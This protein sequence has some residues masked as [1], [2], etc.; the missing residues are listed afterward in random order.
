MDLIALRLLADTRIKSRGPWDVRAEPLKNYSEYFEARELLLIDKPLGE[1]S[2]ESEINDALYWLFDTYW[3]GPMRSYLSSKW[4][5][6]EEI[7]LAE[8]MT[9]WSYLMPPRFLQKVVQMYLKPRLKREVS[10]NW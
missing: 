4:N 8:S 5:V 7:T 1:E 2:K 9:R 10:D 3:L 6:A